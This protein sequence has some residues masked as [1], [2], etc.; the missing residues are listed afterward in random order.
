MKM[1]ILKIGIATM[2]AAL[3]D[4]ARVSAADPI[5][6]KPLYEPGGGGAIVSLEVSPHDTKHIISAGDMLGVATSFDGGNS[7]ESTFGFSS[8]EMATPTFHPA[9]ASVVWI[10]SCMGPY[11]SIDKG[12]H[13]TAKRTGMPA[14][15]KGRYTAIVE[16]V[17]FDPD[18]PTRLLAIGGSSRRWNK[19]ETFGWIWESTDDGESWTHLTTLTPQGAKNEPITGGNIV[20]ADYEPKSTATIHALLDGGIWL[21][22]D[23]DGRSW[24]VQTP[25]GIVGK[26]DSVSFDP[27][28]P[29]I[30]YVSTLSTSVGPTPGG[31]FKST[32]RG[33]TFVA[34]DS[35]IQK[36]VSDPYDKYTTRHFSNVVVSKNDPRSLY[37]CDQAWNASV[38][39]KSTDAGATWS[40]SVTKQPIGQTQAVGDLS[41]AFPLRTAT[42]AGVSMKMSI[43]PNDASKAYGYNTEFVLRTNDGGKSWDDATAYNP[44]ASKPGA[45]RGRGWNGWCSNEVRFNPYKPEQLVVQA[46]DA[47]RAWISDDNGNAWHY[48]DTDVHPWLGGN[49]VSFTRDGHI[50]GTTGQFAQVNG[51]TRSRDGGKTW[52]SLAGENRGLP[53]KGWGKKGSMGGIYAH[54]D[55][56]GEVWAV[57]NGKIL[58]TSDFGD[59]WSPITEAKFSWIEAD[60]TNPDRFYA[61]AKDGIYVTNDGKSLTNI[62]EPK[63]ANRSKLHVDA[64]GRLY[65]TQ[66][67]ESVAGVWRYNPADKSWTRLLDETLA[68]DI[69]SDP[70][71]PTRIIL[72]TSMDPFHDHAGGNGVWISADDGKTWSQ[73]N[74]GLAM[75]RANCVEFDPKNGERFIVGTYGRGFFEATWPRDWKPSG[76]RA[77]AHTPADTA[78]ATPA[79]VGHGIR[80]FGPGSFDYAY[81]ESWKLNDTLKTDSV[82]VTIDGTEF[83]GAGIVLNNDDLAPNGET[84]MV[85]R[86]CTLERNEASSLSLNLNGLPGGSRTLE[87]TLPKP[88]GQLGDVEAELPKMDKL[89]VEQLQI[90]GQNFSPGAAKVRVVIVSIRTTGATRVLEKKLLVEPAAQAVSDGKPKP[91]LRNG[92]FEHGDATPWNWQPSGIGKIER[93]TKEFKEGVASLKVIVD[94]G[95]GHGL[96]RLDLKA[97]DQMRFSGFLK[98][99]GD[100]KVNA[101]VMSFK[102]NS[103]FN[104]FDQIKYAQN[105]SDWTAFDKTVTLPADTDYVQIGVMVSG[106]GTAW[107]DDLKLEINGVPAMAD[108]TKP[109]P[110]PSGEK[111]FEKGLPNTPTHGFYPTYPAAWKQ[112]FH[113]QLERSKKGG[114][115]LVLLGDSI[116]QGWGDTSK[117]PWKTAFPDLVTTNFGIGGDSTR[118]VLYRIEKGLLDGYTAKAVVVMIGTNNLYN[119]FNSGTDQEIADGIVAVVKAVVA[120]Q[121][122]AKVLLVG[123]LPRQNEFFIGRINRINTL[124]SAWA[125][126]SNIRYVDMGESFKVSDK[127]V[128]KE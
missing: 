92:N 108:G 54:P 110:N 41:K 14:T 8:Y 27:T 48:A 76:N 29:Q 46:M 122:E 99:A 100:V 16:K 5:Q 90:Q 20:W 40:A 82:G 15:S 47:G 35:G 17:I 22:S 33:V 79:L 68:F 126:E 96:Q 125:G 55:R 58:H 85:V 117:G 26:I 11:K 73:Q 83:G 19:A 31:V 70:K 65:A 45:W 121:P 104:R 93:D 23:D 119:D 69:A 10:G 43:D 94:G 109:Q 123:M 77:Y 127:Q 115:D 42:R 18:Q 120:K 88:S 118:Q 89:T 91:P 103:N 95:D 61:S 80:D 60:P 1:F 97:G 44:D 7:W 34:S 50:Y 24:S 63:P 114:I 37:V 57:V 9:D 52:E 51:I 4:G 39:Y 101:C 84:R 106:K 25:A 75:L 67:R 32:D 105:D 124:I 116:T 49:A 56:S 3:V 53:D 59:T 71:D 81:G 72:V 28:D 107:I 86:L 36:V 6:F 38:V 64:S 113:G 2:V 12:I 21:K 66:W 30:V 74:E 128:V 111:T 112:T 78:Y 13:W 62:G 102:P 98:S 87:L